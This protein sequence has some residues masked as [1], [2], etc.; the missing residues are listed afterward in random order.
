M[1]KIRKSEVLNTAVG[2]EFRERGFTVFLEKIPHTQYWNYTITNNNIH[3]KS[4]H[5]NGE[6][7]VHHVSNA[8]YDKRKDAIASARD[9]ICQN[10]KE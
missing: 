8:R 5:F 4:Y 3:P 2:W 6:N 7:I 9:W 10:G 1:D